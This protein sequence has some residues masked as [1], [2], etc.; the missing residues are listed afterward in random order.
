M[1]KV[2]AETKSATSIVSMS[3]SYQPEIDGL[4]ALAVVAVIIN[5]F[6]KDILPSGYLGVDIFFVISGFVITSSLAGRP[7]KNLGD[8]LIGFYTRRIKRLVPALVFFVVVTSVFICM[9]NQQPRSLLGIGKTALFGFSNIALYR[10]ETD[11][12]APSTELNPFTHTWSLG[13]EEQFYL[14]FP[15]L[16]WFSGF[17]RLN[18]NGTRNLFWATGALSFA[19]LI[20][21]LYLYPVNQPAAYFLMPARLWEL[22]AGCL[23][24]L[25]LKSS[26]NFFRGFQSVP[27]LFITAMIVGVLFIPFQFAIIATVAIVV[28]TVALIACL[29]SNATEYAF[30][31]DQKVVYIGRISYSLYLWH[32]GVLSLSRW[33]IGIHWWSVPFQITAI[34]LLAIISYKYVE[35]PLRHSTWS[36]LRWGS[37]GYGLGACAAAAMV[38]AGIGG[39]VLRIEIPFRLSDILYLGSFSELEKIYN[40]KK[41]GLQEVKTCNI[42]KNHEDSIALST[43]CGFDAESN[44]STVFL[45]GDS[46]IVQFATPIASYA[47][48]K[49]FG[50]RTVWGNSCLFPSVVIRGDG[51]DCYEL[52][53]RVEQ[54]LLAIAKA[55]DVVFIGNALYARFSGHWGEGEVYKSASGQPLPIRDAARQ[56][57]VRLRQLTDRLAELGVKVVIFLDGPQFHALSEPCDEQWFRPFPSKDCFINKNEYISRRDSDFGWVNAWANGVNKFAWDAIDETTCRGEQ[58]RAAHFSDS[59]HFKEYYADFVFAKFISRFPSVI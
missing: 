31:A 26:G 9:F 20:T 11:Y 3:S 42:F 10:Q 47:K 7:S 1:E 8:S 25:G 28:F 34:V 39:S 23:L 54:S 5:H 24:F 43:N 52:Q 56:Y 38:I 48:K 22:G 57:S 27:P 29:H 59:N 16:V 36:L 13:V 12:F 41:F 18:I 55:G 21:Y 30:F 45:F 49:G 37:I 50:I 58:C 53:R 15:F 35:T 4:R 51:I 6:N 14:L 2:K 17:G 44:R 46:H 33:T 32:W 40:G 19:S